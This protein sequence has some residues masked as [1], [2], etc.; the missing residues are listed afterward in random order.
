MPGA[1]G[2]AV[3]LGPT[4]TAGASSAPSSAPTPRPTV[5]ARPRTDAG[6]ARATTEVASAEELNSALIDAAPGDLIMLAA[7]NYQGN[8]VASTSGTIEEPIT[9]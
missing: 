6:C 5:S 8:F 1:Q 4:S 2:G 9:L 7:G 3:S